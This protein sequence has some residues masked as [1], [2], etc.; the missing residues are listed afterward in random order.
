MRDACSNF[1]GLG[2]QTIWQIH[3][4]HCMSPPQVPLNLE[5]KRKENVTNIIEGYFN[6]TVREDKHTPARIKLSQ[7]MASF[8]REEYENGRKRLYPL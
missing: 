2:H 3:Q 6:N 1:H 4:L 5:K 8:R 7:R